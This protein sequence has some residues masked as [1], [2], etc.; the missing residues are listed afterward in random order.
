M[1]VTTLPPPAVEAPQHF[2]DC[3]SR[4]IGRRVKAMSQVSRRRLYLANLAT[5]LDEFRGHCDCFALQLTRVEA[6]LSARRKAA[7]AGYSC[8]TEIAAL[9][10]ARDALREA[11]A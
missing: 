5:P 8:D 3:D 9:T 4:A 6:D 10:V 1:S 2:S 7:R 11:M